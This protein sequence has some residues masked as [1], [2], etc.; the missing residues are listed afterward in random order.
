[1]KTGVVIN[2]SSHLN[3]RSGAS[4]NC[5]VVGILKNEDRVDIIDEVSELDNKNIL[6]Y[7]INFELS[8][9]FVRA[10]YIKLID[11]NIL[12]SNKLV[13]FV[14]SYEGFSSTPYLDSAGVKTI[15]Y[16]STHGDIISKAHVTKEEA[17]SALMTEINSMAKLIKKDLIERGVTLNQNEF[18]SLCSFAYNCGVNALI[19]QS[20]LYKRICDGVRDSSLEENFEAWSHAGKRVLQGLLRRRKAEYKIFMFG[21]YENN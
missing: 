9:G 2:V 10:D 21:V 7:K 17:T 16:G 20:T 18:D 13:E 12:I 3:V 6:W 8:V 14:K 19:N 5:E 11:D 15:G 1:M 4:T